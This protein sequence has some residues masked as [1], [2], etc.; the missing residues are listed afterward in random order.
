MGQESTEREKTLQ[1]L[2]ERKRNTKA[3][4]T[5][6]MRNCQLSHFKSFMEGK[7]VQEL[8]FL[9]GQKKR[10]EHMYCDT[11]GGADSCQSEEPPEALKT[12]KN[13]VSWWAG[14]IPWPLQVVIVCLPCCRLQSNTRQKLLCWD[15]SASSPSELPHK[16]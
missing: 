8:F 1:K 9:N 11:R 4:P 16:E 14:H 12:G 10:Y 7:K 5:Q 13:W 6:A 3:V 2:R 15:P